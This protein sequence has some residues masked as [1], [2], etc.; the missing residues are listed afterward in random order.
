MKLIPYKLLYG[1]LTTTALG[2][3]P[4]S[5]AESPVHHM[6]SEREIT[7]HDAKR[8][9]QAFENVSGQGLCAEP[10]RERLREGFL[11]DANSEALATAIEKRASSLLDAQSIIG[12]RPGIGRGGEMVPGLHRILARALESGLPPDI[13]LDLFA[14]PERVVAYREQ[15]LI[16]AAEMLFL[17]EVDPE[18][19]KRF[20]HEALD[21]Q[22]R[23][24]EILRAAQFWIRQQAEGISA[25]GIHSRLW[26]NPHATP[27]QGGGMGRRMLDQQ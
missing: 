15:A 3:I 6:L 25:A 21:R 14:D 27:V 11:K 4:L 19:I 13:F 7:G 26:G 24:M 9:L 2:W 23:R 1:F 22:L 20:M 17:S 12:S 8:I 5:S 10:L 16:E 18:D